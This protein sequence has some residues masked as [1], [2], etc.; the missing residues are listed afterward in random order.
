MDYGGARLAGLRPTAC[1]RPLGVPFGC[2]TLPWSMEPWAGS[3]AWHGPPFAAT[4]VPL[5]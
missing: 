4:T 3:R 5:R 1:L 2:A